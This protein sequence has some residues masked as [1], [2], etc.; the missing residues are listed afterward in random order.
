M[1]FL[2]I[3]RRLFLSKAWVLVPLEFP[4]FFHSSVRGNPSVLKVSFI[5]LHLLFGINKL[6]YKLEISNPKYLLVG[7][8][9]TPEKVSSIFLSKLQVG[10]WA[11]FSLLWKVKIRLGRWIS[12]ACQ[13]RHSP[14]HS[15]QQSQCKLPLGLARRP[16][17]AKDTAG[18]S[19]CFR[20]ER[21]F[22]TEN[23]Y[24]VTQ[25]AK[26]FETCRLAELRAS[27]QLSDFSVSDAARIS[28]EFEMVGGK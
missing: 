12:L 23:P 11:F 20:G 22:T 14:C 18:T 26:E 13:S 16:L 27:L 21:P 10:R 5:P 15:S 4:V 24:S 3:Y 28:E 7:E 8:I 2:H 1:L 19:T 6:V 17:L 9:R 25:E